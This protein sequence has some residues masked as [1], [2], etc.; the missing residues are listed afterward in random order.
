MTFSGVQLSIRSFCFIPFYMHLHYP[1]K[2]WEP[3]APFFLKKLEEFQQKVK[4]K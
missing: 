1:I 3:Q 4:E 2:L